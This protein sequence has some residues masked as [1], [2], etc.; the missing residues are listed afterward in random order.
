MHCCGDMSWALLF[1]AM[2]GP[3]SQRQAV[4]D[5]GKA[6]SGKTANTHVICWLNGVNLKDGFVIRIC[7]SD[8]GRE[9]NPAPVWHA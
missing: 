4:I 1:E 2:H 8:A 5:A 7:M 6:S 3:R 9:T